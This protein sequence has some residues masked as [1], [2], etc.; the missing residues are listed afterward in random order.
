M[1]QQAEEIVAKSDVLSSI[2][3]THMVER[4]KLPL[5]IVLWPHIYT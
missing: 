5:H 3:R 1:A 4:E 2:P